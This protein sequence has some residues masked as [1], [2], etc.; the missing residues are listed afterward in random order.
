PFF[1][2]TH[3]N[4]MGLASRQ[5]RTAGRSGPLAEAQRPFVGPWV[6]IRGADVLVA[7]G[8]PKEV[9]SWLA[10]HQQQAQSVFRVPGSEQPASGAA[11]Q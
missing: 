1:G 3:A 8:S 10:R 4:P 7:A 9:V 6:A 11:P 2:A 5:A